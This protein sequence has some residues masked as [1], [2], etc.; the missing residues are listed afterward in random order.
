MGWSPTQKRRRPPARKMSEAR[1]RAGKSGRPVRQEERVAIPEG[2]AETV[3][4]PGPRGG[5]SADSQDGGRRIS[6]QQVLQRRD[7]C[8]PL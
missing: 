8:P 3:G 6:G 1:V 2:K 5:G 7:R 4:P